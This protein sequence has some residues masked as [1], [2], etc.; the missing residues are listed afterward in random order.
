MHT[1]SY[2]LKYHLPL[3]LMLLASIALAFGFI[4]FLRLAWR[5]K[6]IPVIAVWT[7]IAFGCAIAATILFYVFGVRVGFFRF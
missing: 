1:W 3:A 5:A 7:F 4:W 2:H 6:S